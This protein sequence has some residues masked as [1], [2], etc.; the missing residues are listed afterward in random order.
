MSGHSGDTGSGST[1]RPS[2]RE[3]G[4]LSGKAH[5]WRGWGRRRENRG[6]PL[7]HARR[8]PPALRGTEPGARGIL[9]LGSEIAPRECPTR[10]R[11][12]ETSPSKADREP[13]PPLLHLPI[14]RRGFLGQHSTGGPTAPSHCPCPRSPA[15]GPC[16]APSCWC[17]P[18]FCWNPKQLSP[19]LSV[20]REEAQGRAV[21]GRRGRGSRGPTGGRS[22]SWW[23][24]QR[25]AIELAGT[26]RATL[27]LLLCV[28]GAQ[29]H[30]TPNCPMAISVP[31][32]APLRGPCR[33]A[34][35][36]GS[37]Q[38]WRAGSLSRA[39]QPIYSSREGFRFGSVRS[40]IEGPH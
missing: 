17:H 12:L 14:A 13:S 32:P 26:F 10:I 38:T 30:I 36:K 40:I 25:L 6:S 2:P 21:A 29:K 24:P 16:L 37:S 1:W 5:G 11:V 9:P 22:Q 23:Q 35:D 20:C 18:E 33:R 31:R 27:P 34:G 8:P 28:F 15:P 19:K 4:A 3:D 39:R 7:A